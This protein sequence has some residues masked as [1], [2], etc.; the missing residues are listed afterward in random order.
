MVYRQVGYRELAGEEEEE[1]LVLGEVTR[2]GGEGLGGRGEDCVD[3]GIAP[4]ERENLG[5][6]F[7][8]YRSYTPWRGSFQGTILRAGR[9]LYTY[10]GT[11][12]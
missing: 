9:R 8:P 11:A 3:L 7:H 12:R 5:R 1:V 2:D 6:Y 10:G 4:G